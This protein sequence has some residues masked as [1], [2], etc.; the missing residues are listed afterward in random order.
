M[1]TIL[2]RTTL[3]NS[4]CLT[5]IANKNINSILF[6]TVAFFAFNIIYDASSPIKTGPCFAK[7]DFTFVS[8]VLIGA[9]TSES[10]AL[11]RANSVVLLIESFSVSSSEPIF[12]NKSLLTIFCLDHQKYQIFFTYT[13]KVKSKFAVVL[14][15]SQSFL[16]IYVGLDTIYGT[17]TYVNKIYTQ[18]YLRCDLTYRIWRYGFILVSYCILSENSCVVY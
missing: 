4:W 1:T 16:L 12:W 10:V 9:I 8:S 18:D 3:A 5:N 2:T 7:F 6:S 15:I 17:L 14:S 13:G 11:W